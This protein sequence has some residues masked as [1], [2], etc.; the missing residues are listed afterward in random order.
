MHMIGLPEPEGT[1]PLSSLPPPETPDP[2]KFWFCKH[3][4]CQ[5]QIVIFPAEEILYELSDDP[6]K[7]ICLDCYT[8]GYMDWRNAPVQFTSDE[9]R[10]WLTDELDQRSARAKHITHQD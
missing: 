3:C 7:Y 1:L 5:N 9:H 8:S 2:G 10:R 4:C 6:R